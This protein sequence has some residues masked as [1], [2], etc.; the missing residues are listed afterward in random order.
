[1]PISLVKPLALTIALS[2]LW[3][4]PCHSEQVG[5]LFFT[6][7][8]RAALDLQ[9]KTGVAPMPNSVEANL[10]NLPESE[11]TINGIVK[12]S[13]GKSTVWIN[14]MAQTE[15][16]Q[17]GDTR[18]RARQT[19][20]PNVTVFVPSLG[21]AVALKVGQTLDVETREIRDVH[22][23]APAKGRTTATPNTPEPSA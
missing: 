4:V 15:A 5:R 11:I 20:L 17:T 21:K 13:D 2:A 8:Q 3:S 6:P 22:Q 19:N 10:P 16:S 12:R 23:P 9:R 14:Q 7:E 1:M 18:T